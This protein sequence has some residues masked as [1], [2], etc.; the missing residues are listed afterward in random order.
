M[1]LFEMT[2]EQ[3]DEVFDGGVGKYRV[4]NLL[5]KTKV[6]YVLNIQVPGSENLALRF[7]NFTSKGDSAKQVKPGDKFMQT[8]VIQISEKGTPQILRD[9]L[10]SDPIGAMNMITDEIV[11]MLVRYRMDATLLMFPTKALKGQAKNIARITSRLLQKRSGGKFIVLPELLERGKKYTYIMIY[12]KSTG[13][14][15]VKGLEIDPELYTVSSTS[16]GDVVIDVKTGEKVTKAEAI[17]GSIEKRE[18]KRSTKSMTNFKIPRGDLIKA[19]TT[20]I[21][22]SDKENNYYD[23]FGVGP[24]EKKPPTSEAEEAVINAYNTITKE[25]IRKSHYYKFSNLA[26]ANSLDKIDFDKYDASSHELLALY[27]ETVRQTSEKA[28]QKWVDENIPD[29]HPGVKKGKVDFMVY[30]EVRRAIMEWANYL[31]NKF[32]DTVGSVNMRKRLPP[33]CVDAIQTYTSN[34]YRKI[35]NVFI[36]N[37]KPSAKTVNDIQNLD[38]AFDIAGIKLPE[39]LT[40]WR[41]MTCPNYPAK[42]ALENKMFYFSNYVSCSA[43]PIVFLGGSIAEHD[44]DILNAKEND[45]TQVETAEKHG[46]HFAFAIKNVQVPALIVNGMSNYTKEREIV[47]PRGTIFEFKKVSNV[48]EFTSGKRKYLIDCSAVFKSQIDESTEIYDGDLLMQTGEVKLIEGFSGFMK[49]REDEE[50][51]RL[52]AEKIQRDNYLSTLIDL[53]GESKFVQVIE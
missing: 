8:Q 45:D 32:D 43:V 31:G 42:V 3:L 10:G 18:E 33:E 1:M 44:I 23:Q 34:D 11:N 46:A 41:G 19:F 9:G 16:V 47:L 5:P 14:T 29:E 52:K 48:G 40:L 20:S 24:V 15:S 17:A 6:P 49:S 36:A 39:N 22:S 26:A 53:G 13:I 28:A 21:A 27:A 30:K 37:I 50:K 51:E 4:V 7:C 35:N 38:R 25:Q 12:R 2:D